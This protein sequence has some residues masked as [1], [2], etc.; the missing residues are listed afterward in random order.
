MGSRPRDNVYSISLEK[1]KLSKNPKD[2]LDQT[3]AC[4]DFLNQSS[5]PVETPFAPEDD[6]LGEKYRTLL[7]QI[8]NLLAESMVH[9]QK[10]LTEI[11]IDYLFMLQIFNA[12]DHGI[13]ALDKSRTILRVNKKLLCFIGKPIKAVVGKKCYEVFSNCESYLGRGRCHG[14][15]ILAGEKLLKRR[16]TIT[17]DDGEAIPMNVVSTPLPGLN[18]AAFGVVETFMDIG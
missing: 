2:N 4:P 12:S 7:R 15:Q 11:E 9:S 18:G 8:E 14:E 5:I 13:W 10:V 17:S 6:L 1:L 3:I 16:T